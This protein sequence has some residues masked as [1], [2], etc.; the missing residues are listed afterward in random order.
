[1][2][3]R[4]TAK[5]HALR[6]ISEAT[7]QQTVID[8]AER[9]QWRWYAPPRNGIRRH[10]TVRTVP[11]GFPDLVLARGP[12]LVFAELKRETGKASEAQERWAEALTRAS[13]EVYQWRPSDLDEVRAVLGRRP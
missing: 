7:W 12:R 5:D 13:A 10:G 6:A 2:S 9:L 1:M 3:A 8:L 4:L 11:P